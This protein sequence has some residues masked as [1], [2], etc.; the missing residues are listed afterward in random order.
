VARCGIPTDVASRHF[1]NN[2]ATL[3]ATNLPLPSPSHL[4]IDDGEKAY[5]LPVCIYPDDIFYAVRIAYSYENAGRLGR[6]AH[7]LREGRS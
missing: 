1:T 3:T 6:R 7:W 2:S 4:K 5:G